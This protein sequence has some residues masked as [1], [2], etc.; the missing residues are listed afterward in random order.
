[1][2]IKLE[3]HVFVNPEVCYLV[4]ILK[5]ALGFFSNGDM[6]GFMSLP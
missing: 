6:S 1:M 4:S 3:V 5:L 2:V